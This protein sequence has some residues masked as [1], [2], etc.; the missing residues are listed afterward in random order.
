LSV[1]VVSVFIGY[2]LDQWL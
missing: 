2:K 1:S